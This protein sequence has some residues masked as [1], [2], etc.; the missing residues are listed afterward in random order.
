MEANLEKRDIKQAYQKI[1]VRGKINI[2]YEKKKKTFSKKA[3]RQAVCY[4]I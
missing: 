4:S 2:S 1:T 3:G